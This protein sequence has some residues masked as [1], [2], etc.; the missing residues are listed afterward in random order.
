MTKMTLE[1]MVQVGDKGPVTKAADCG[2][3]GAGPRLM[4]DDGFAS[5]TPER[6]RSSIGGL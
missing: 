4:L 3:G 2:A 5:D 1:V 6:M